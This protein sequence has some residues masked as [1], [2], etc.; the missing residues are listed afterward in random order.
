LKSLG[1]LLRKLLAALL[2]FLLDLPPKCFYG[3]G[4]D[5]PVATNP[6][7]HQL[8]LSAQLPYVVGCIAK[9]LT[10]HC[11]GNTFLLIKT[12]VHALPTL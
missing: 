2:F 6:F 5:I 7:A 10:R 3:R 8:P 12:I 9:N 4:I 1:T 11:G